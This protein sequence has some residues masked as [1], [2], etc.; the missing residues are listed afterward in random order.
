MLVQAWALIPRLGLRF[1]IKVGIA[2]GRLRQAKRH[3]VKVI[4]RETGSPQLRIPDQF[5]RVPLAVDG[6]R[7]H[8]KIA[9]AAPFLNCIETVPRRK[10][11]NICNAQ[12]SPATYIR[13]ECSF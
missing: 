7:C 12:K 1:A 10:N 9:A 3:M 11:Q 6:P 13:L 2:L 4:W 8:F 5:R